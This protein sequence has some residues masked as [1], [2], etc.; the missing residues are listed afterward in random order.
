MPVNVSAKEAQEL[1]GRLKTLIEDAE[2]V[3]DTRFRI[4]KEHYKNYNSIRSK[5]FYVG[6]ADVFVPFSYIVV[7]TLVSKI[8]KIIYSEP[9]LVSLEG[10]G[11]TDKDREERVRALLHHQQK[12]NVK[13][14]TKLAD[15][16]RTRCI[17]GRSYAEIDWRTEWKTVKKNKVVDKDGQDVDD[18]TD[19]Q[20][21]SP[22]EE[23]LRD[24]QELDLPG[25][26]DGDLSRPSPV[27]EAGIADDKRVRVETTEE[28]VAT[29]DCWD[30]TNLD[31]F[32]V[33]VDPMAP[34]ASI[35]RAK[36]AAVRSYIE[37]DDL[38]EWGNR[39]DADGKPIFENWQDAIDSGVGAID[40]DLEDRKNL[41]GLNINV[42]KELRGDSKRHELHKIFLNY[43]F[44]GDKHVSKNAVFYL[45]DRQTLI[46]AEKNP[47]WHGKKNIIS[48]AY[49]RRPN[50][51]LGQSALDPIRKIQYEINDKRNQE[52][53]AAG[54]V[55]NPIWLVGD[56]A[57]LEDENIRISQQTA[58][59]VADV[60]AIKPLVF[61]DMT[62]V[63]QRAGA[64]LEENLRET[65][66]VTRSIQ[67][68]SDPGRQTAQEF[69]QLINQASERIFMVLSIWSRRLA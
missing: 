29:Y 65:T 15:Y 10:I 24:L 48:G 17:Y 5:R 4:A 2:D 33:L 46:R 69:N 55:L 25:A 42:L 41:L 12:K 14:W 59:K 40:E 30:F 22:E 43:K 20:S 21:F 1:E 58:I 7:E 56:D 63:G 45:L 50:E 52:L 35:Q 44:D 11:P 32:D 34:D 6:R 8:M 37:D 31:F 13:L 54:F 9:V 64:I 26:D 36:W 62:S 66:G 67:G 27:R 18:L 53:D 28:R 16:W 49:T 39:E 47:W 57:E 51:F 68:I 19:F 60:N 61:P 3:Y 23:E 38:E